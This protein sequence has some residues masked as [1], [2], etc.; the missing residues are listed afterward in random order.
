[1]SDLAY[2][3]AER[4]PSCDERAVLTESQADRMAA[5]SGGRL[6]AFVCLDG[7]GWHVWNP[8]FERPW[9]R[10]RST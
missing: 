2:T 10:T 9:D 5:A 8:D 6:E 7:R 1:M 4:C 3:N